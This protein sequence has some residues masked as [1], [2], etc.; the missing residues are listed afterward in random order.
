MLQS[1]VIMQSALSVF[2]IVFWGEKANGRGN[3]LI[4][5]KH[6]NNNKEVILFW[7]NI[8]LYNLGPN[9][10]ISKKVHHTWWSTNYC[11]SC[12]IKCWAEWYHVCAACG[13]MKVTA[14]NYTALHC[15]ARLKTLSVHHE[16]MRYPITG[17]KHCVLS[18]FQTVTFALSTAI[19][20]PPKLSVFA[21]CL[22][23]CREL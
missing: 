22:Q 2:Y 3:I 12:T 7:E 6:Q 21:L 16:C 17:D 11:T 20:I 14:V 5:T 19:K 10:R 15:T 8:I 4:N 18:L 23:P 9:K 13:W 1:A